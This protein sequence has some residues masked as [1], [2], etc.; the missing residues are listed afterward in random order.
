MGYTYLG[1]IEYWETFGAGELAV[2]VP[3]RDANSAVG[4]SI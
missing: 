4:L 2:R 1:G 3:L